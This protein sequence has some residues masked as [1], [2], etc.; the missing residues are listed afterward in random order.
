MSKKKNPL[1]NNHPNRK[2]NEIFLLYY[3]KKNRWFLK[4]WHNHTCLKNHFQNHL[5]SSI[6]INYKLNQHWGELGHWVLEKLKNWPQVSK[7]ESFE[8]MNKVKKINY[9]K[10][11]SY[12]HWFLIL[13]W[14]LIVNYYT[15][16][17]PKVK[18]KVSVLLTR[19]S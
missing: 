11:I 1:L 17:K 6:P 14:S 15:D 13:L 12:K 16:I 9:Q 8:W 4:K 3:R 5:V 18:L 7:K 10:I 19:L 2:F